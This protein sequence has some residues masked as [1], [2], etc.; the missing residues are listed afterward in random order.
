MSG[1]EDLDITDTG[2]IALTASN[3]SKLKQTLGDYNPTELAAFLQMTA[4]VCRKMGFVALEM[5]CW[6]KSIRQE[7]YA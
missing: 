7:R 6:Q 2:D 5:L 3:F 1:I 4:A